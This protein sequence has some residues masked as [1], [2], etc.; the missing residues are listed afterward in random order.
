MTKAMR[1]KQFEETDK[2][3]KQMIHAAAAKRRE[4]TECL[5]KARMEQLQAAQQ[6]N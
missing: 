4:K 2:T 3:A 5:S 1:E 6:K